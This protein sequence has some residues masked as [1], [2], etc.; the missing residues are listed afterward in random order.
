VWPALQRVVKPAAGREERAY[1]PTGP[2]GVV[3]DSARGKVSRG[4]WETRSG[5]GDDANARREYITAGRPV[6]ESEGFIVAE[7][8]LITVEQRDP[9]EGAFG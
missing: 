1:A 3:V 2:P 9:A 5:S 7:K 4:T 8:R 6:R